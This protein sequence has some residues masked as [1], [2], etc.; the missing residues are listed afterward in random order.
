ML[1][2]RA[3]LIFEGDTQTWS[4]SLYI[5]RIKQKFGR[6]HQLGPRRSEKSE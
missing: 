1:K 6:R 5:S 3:L 4:K 2:I